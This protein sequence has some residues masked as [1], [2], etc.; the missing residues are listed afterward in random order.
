MAAR[1]SCP[2][3]G[4]VPK[5]AD[6]LPPGKK[7]RCRKCGEVYPIP[8]DDEEP[9]RITRRG[10]AD[11][12]GDDDD[13]EERRPRRRRKVKAG[14]GALLPILIGVGVGA[15]LLVGVAVAVAVSWFSRLPEMANAP[16]PPG[17]AQ[18]QFG[19]GQLPPPM[20]GQ[21]PVGGQGQAPAPPPNNGP[22]PA[23]PPTGGGRVGTD[24]GMTAKEI[25]G[26]DIDGKRFKLSDYRGKVVLLDFWGHW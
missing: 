7:I 21:P 12:D 24:V 16:N 15:L 25:E 1:L 2:S 5:V 14:S 26:E 3:C 13:G 4:A 6:D 9:E 22:N 20:R 19:P 23:S 10:R 8:A 17:N 18:P 11:D